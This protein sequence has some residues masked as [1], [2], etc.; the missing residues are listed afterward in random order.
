[1]ARGIKK[2]LLKAGFVVFIVFFL[3][4]GILMHTGTGGLVR[5]ISR[6]G[7]WIGLFMI[8]VGIFQR[9]KITDDNAIQQVKGDPSLP[10]KC[11]KCGRTYDNSWK[12][13]LQCSVALIS[14]K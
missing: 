11:P 13:C 2:P 8:I 4:N 12:V 10:L 5:D 6:L 1:M 3:T 7:A 14:N 9:K